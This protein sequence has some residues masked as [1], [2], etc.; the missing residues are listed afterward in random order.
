LSN[1]PWKAASSGSAMALTAA[2]AVDDDDSRRRS[3]TVRTW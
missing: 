2:L 1:A 3:H